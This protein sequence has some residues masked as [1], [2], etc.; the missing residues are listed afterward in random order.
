MPPQQLGE[1]EEKGEEEGA[2]AA[3]AVRRCSRHRSSALRA[4]RK[5]CSC[6]SCPPTGRRPSR[7]AVRPRDATCRTGWRPPLLGGYA[8]CG[9]H[10]V[11]FPALSLLLP[12]EAMWAAVGAQVGAA[13][14]VGAA[15]A[16]VV[17][18]VVVVAVGVAVMGMAGR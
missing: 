8:A 13:V 12:L 17:V 18:V 3:A 6:P 9:T 1:E 11:L 2:K 7:Q 15:A 5:R 10:R 4:W 14:A 16:V